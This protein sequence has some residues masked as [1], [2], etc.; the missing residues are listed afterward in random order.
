[1]KKS[2][3]KGQSC[4]PSELSAGDKGVTSCPPDLNKSVKCALSNEIKNFDPKTARKD[5]ED[6][7][8]GG[9]SSDAY[10]RWLDQNGGHE[11]IEANPDVLSESDGINYLPSK[12]DSE[13]ANLLTEVR[14]L[15]S[16]RE[17]QVWNLVMRHN[18]PQQEAADLLNISRS[19]LRFYLKRANKKFKEFMEAKK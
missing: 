13:S 3:R 16:T 15:L 14:Q 9:A 6:S 12:E 19:S 4:H 7:A 2:I 10:N 5:A 1:M 11:P 17:L 18:L 8:N